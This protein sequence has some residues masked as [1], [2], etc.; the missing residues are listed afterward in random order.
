MGTPCTKPKPTLGHILQVYYS[1][2]YRIG[3]CYLKEN[4]Q[5]FGFSFQ[6]AII[7][8][9]LQIS[10]HLVF[11]V[12]KN[13][14][15]TSFVF[16]YFKKTQLSTLRALKDDYSKKCCILLPIYILYYI[17]GHAHAIQTIICHLVKSITEKVNTYVL[18]KF[19]LSTNSSRHIGANSILSCKQCKNQSYKG[20]VSSG[21]CCCT[22]CV[23]SEL[24]VMLSNEKKI[25]IDC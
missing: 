17:F 8:G 13:D 9:D 14:P 23:S 4:Q 7:Y 1:D 3:S 12:K 16:A 5:I 15:F 10:S 25:V 6:I 11:R 24:Y 19:K 21:L 20:G 18:L 2:K 22:A